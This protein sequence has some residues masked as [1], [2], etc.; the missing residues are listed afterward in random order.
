[1]SDVQYLHSDSQVEPEPKHHF[2]LSLFQQGQFSV[3]ARP[4]HLQDKY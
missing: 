4:C 3:D 2:V 1:V